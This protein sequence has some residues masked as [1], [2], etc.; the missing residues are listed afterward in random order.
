MPGPFGA[1]EP[2]DE[3][4]Q[5]PEPK[6]EPAAAES[7][8]DSTQRPAEDHVEHED[9]VV[10]ARA[11]KKTE[12][13]S[14]RYKLAMLAADDDDFRVEM[15]RQRLVS[16]IDKITREL[17]DGRFDDAAQRKACP[18]CGELSLPD[19]DFCEGCGEALTGEPIRVPRPVPESQIDDDWATT[20]PSRENLPWI[21]GGAVFAVVVLVALCS[22]IISSVGGTASSEMAAQGAV[23]AR[24]KAPSTAEF[25][26]TEKFGEG[27]YFVVV[28]AQNS[29]GAPI[30]G[31]FCV[32]LPESGQSEQVFE[33][34][35][36]EAVAIF[37]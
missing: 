16:R 21:V 5:R 1:E 3:P 14:L 36:E 25:V 32:V 31:R 18:H 24:L 15:E 9:P 12:L 4:Q 17:E 10:A 22:G 23:L 33:C 20:P 35:R 28:D 8:P 6:P 13:A 37:E 11:A 2:K 7:A 27:T 34:T 26:S 29:F 19:V 30:R